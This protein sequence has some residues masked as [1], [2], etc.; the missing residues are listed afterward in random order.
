MEGTPLPDYFTA[1]PPPVNIYPRVEAVQQFI[2]HHHSSGTAACRMVLITSGG[3]TVPLEKHTV[4][5]IDNFSLG[6]RGSA[7]AEYFLRNDY[8]VIFMHRTGSLV[9][10][11]RQLNGTCSN[12]F[13]SLEFATDTTIKGKQEL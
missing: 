5:F 6:T 11:S 7:S 10:F 3:T 1:N 4:R 2:R 9:P 13:D 12:L 8:A